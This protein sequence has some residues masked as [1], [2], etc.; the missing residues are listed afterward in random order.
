MCLNYTIKI[1][2]KERHETSHVHTKLLYGAEK[3]IKM[4]MISNIKETALYFIILL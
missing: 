2:I 4:N 3:A 1:Q